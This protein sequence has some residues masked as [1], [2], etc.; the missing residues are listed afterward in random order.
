MPSLK[1]VASIADQPDKLPEGKKDAWPIASLEEGVH[2]YLE[3][4]LFVFTER[5]HLAR[6]RCCGNSCRH[7]PYDHANVK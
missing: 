1:W 3:G 5:Y 2:Y 7:C 6:G 4:E